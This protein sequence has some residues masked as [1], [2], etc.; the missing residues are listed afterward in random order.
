[1]N[2]ERVALRQII[3]K[4]M[5]KPTRSKEVD[6]ASIKTKRTQLTD[7]GKKLSSYFETIHAVLLR[8]EKT[9]K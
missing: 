4:D 1:M 7:V 8:A 9:L 5:L 6:S 2:G 3:A